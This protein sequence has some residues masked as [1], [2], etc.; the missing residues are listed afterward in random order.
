[1]CVIMKFHDIWTML[2]PHTEP[3]KML[4]KIK[5]APRLPANFFVVLLC[6]HARDRLKSRA[7]RYC[8]GPEF[9]FL[10]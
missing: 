9:R 4:Q 8:W 1:M 5:M 3:L 6:I 10:P 7:K 2:R